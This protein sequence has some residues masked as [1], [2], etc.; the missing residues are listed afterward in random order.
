MED[1]NKK[2]NGERNE[3]R[4]WMMEAKERE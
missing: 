2:G 3:G 4:V 1:D